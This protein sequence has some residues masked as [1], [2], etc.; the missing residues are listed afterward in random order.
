MEQ[1]DLLLGGSYLITM[2]HCD[3][4]VKDGAVAVK[5]GKIAA[6]DTL[7]NLRARYAAKQEIVHENAVLLPGLINAHCHET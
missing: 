3:T 5:D 1:C 7:T 6:I 4:R 2:D